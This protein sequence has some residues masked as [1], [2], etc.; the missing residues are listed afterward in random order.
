[1]LKNYLLIAMRNLLKNKVYSFINI[2]GLSVGI[3][4]CVLLGLYI[5]DELS[6]EKHFEGADRVYRI[7]STFVQKDLPNELIQRTSPPVAM[8][9]LEEIPELESATRVVS[10]PE[11]TQH[12][13]KYKDKAL[14]EELGFLVD[15]TFFQVFPYAFKE[16]NPATALNT[17][18][19][20]VLTEK[21]A[22]KFFGDQSP[23]DELI[24]ISSGQSTDTF[25]ITGVLQP[26][27]KKSHVDADFY[28]SM[29]SKGWGEWINSVTTW[30]SQNFIFS[31]LK[32]KPTATSTDVL[33]KF[34]PLMQKYGAADSRAMGR[35]KIHGLQSLLDVHLY[36]THFTYPFDLGKPGNVTYLYILASIGFFI[37]ALACINFV[38]LTTAKATQ[39]AGEV[40]IRKTIGATR[41][42]LIR[43]F[44]GESMTLAFIAMVFSLGLV[45][46]LLPL[47]NTLAEKEL[48]LTSENFRY[49]VIL[50]TIVTLVAGFVAGSYPAFFLS[51][52]QPAKALKD[53]RMSLGS[54]NYLRK[55]MVVFQFVV[56]ITLIVS[57][58]IIQKQLHYIQTKAL[59]FNADEVL[60]VPLRFP[61]DVAAGN[62]E[63]FKVAA[64][65]IAGVQEVSA[66]S[67]A[68]S[69]QLMRDFSV[70]LPGGSME[71]AIHH[72]NMSVDEGF[73]K[74][75][76]IPIIAGRDLVFEIDSTSW[77]KPNKNV[78]VNRASLHE[79]GIQLDGAVGSQFIT[80][81][82]GLTVYHTIVGVI[83]DFHQN[84]L[85]EGIEPIIFF[86]PAV[87][88]DFVYSTILISGTD[89][90]NIIAQLATAWKSLGSD[91]PF[92]S[93]LL[94]EGVKRQYSD[95]ER[96]ST[97]IGIFTTVAIIISC[98]GLYG[99]SV[100]MAERRIKE[101]GIRKVLGASVNKIVAMLSK[102]FIVLVLIAF[103]LSVPISYY[104]MSK[105]LE[106]FA[107]RTEIG[108]T[109]FIL[110]GSI[111]IAIAWL[112]VGFESIRAAIGN[113]VD[114]LR[115]E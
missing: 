48:A 58:L 55:S 43:Q 57:V 6:Y 84:S 72:Y 1:M 14:F 13:L 3:T 33:A 98:L 18:S 94:R 40:G 32:V 100:S 16:G 37:L 42:I 99:L 19:S 54:S 36:S 9:M 90:E 93:E 53:K 8:A 27:E 73:F 21:V 34:P 83:E 112:T 56:A 80:E 50:L 26:I 78:L 4:C 91:T 74:S 86:M 5:K 41:A 45:Q 107:F 71:K 113:P 67:S 62:Y 46:L 81:W 97:I 115:N 24:V 111:A 114:S 66:G 51:S 63:R 15:S 101:I 85:R 49:V 20:V 87:K 110:S 96:V 60:K 7:T 106:N 89:H 92:E 77:A 76:R 61:A 102:D 69:A 82:Q 22:K 12:L 88:N 109:L 35:E 28:M 64:K 38:N 23:I 105:W 44:L 59:G 65:Q 103:V 25:R 68:P 11:V 31:Y 75:L 104:A 95:D 70:Y 29:N 47:F 30:D 10:P 108:I 17:P 79:L 52:F 2:F 39:R